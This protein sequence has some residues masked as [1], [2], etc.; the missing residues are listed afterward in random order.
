MNLINKHYTR[1]T[2][3]VFEAVSNREWMPYL[4]ANLELFC[5]S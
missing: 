1:Q 5:F 2:D 3:D 4:I